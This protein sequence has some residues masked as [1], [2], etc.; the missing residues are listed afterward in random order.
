MCVHDKFIGRYERGRINGPIVDKQAIE[1]GGREKKMG[2]E[3]ERE[4]DLGE[5]QKKATNLKGFV[6]DKCVL[7]IGVAAHMSQPHKYHR[8]QALF[9][10]LRLLLQLLS[11]VKS[12]K[13]SKCGQLACEV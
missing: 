6:C 9:L 2:R 4:W 1:R 3:R 12:M 11:E 7:C 10:L 13:T 5:Q 8:K